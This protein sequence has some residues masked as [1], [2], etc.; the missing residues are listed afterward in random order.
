MR[1]NKNKK[2]RNIIGVTQSVLIFVLVVLV[3][4]MMIQIDRLQGTARVINYAGLVRGATQREVKLE[5]AGSENDELI[6]YL[7]D[8]LSGLKYQDGHYDLVKLHDKEYQNKL[9]V[10]IDYWD[11]IKKEIE[12]VRSGGYK[13]TDI[14]NM[15]ENYFSMADDTVSAAEKYSEK[16]AIKIRRIEILSALDMMCLVILVVIQTLAAMKMAVQNKLLEQKAY[17]DSRTGLP[18]RSSC[19]EILNNKEIIKEPTACIV[20]D[21]NNLKEVNDTIGH[22]AGDSMIANFAHILRKVVP[23]K[24]F[25]GRFGGDE[26]IAILYDTTSGQADELLE[27]LHATIEQYHSSNMPDA[28]SY[29]YGYSYSMN[30]KDCTLRNLLD[31]A[32]HEMYL[33]KQAQK[34]KR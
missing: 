17:T 7:D 2:S 1:L 5:I 25:V 27:K 22:A 23:E 24:D 16:I 6:E 8:I 15:S 26:F 19:K 28:I 18:N 21:L 4:I 30:Y 10:Q 3:V 31:K 32:D 29:A 11:E 34:K 14:V 33:N 9:Q 12:A 13:N 20:F